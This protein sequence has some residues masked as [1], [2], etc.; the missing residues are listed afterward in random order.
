[1]SKNPITVFVDY[2]NTLNNK[3]SHHLLDKLAELKENG[4]AIILTTGGTDKMAQKYLAELDSQGYGGLFD[5]ALSYDKIGTAKHNES[6][7][8]KTSEHLNSHH[9]PCDIKHAIVVDDDVHVLQHAKKKGLSPIFSKEGDVAAVKLQNQFSK[10][11]F[12][13]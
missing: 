3:D 5:H 7:W 10:L 12:S 1:M 9:I 2:G 6:Y 8:N 4:A 13:A 11:K